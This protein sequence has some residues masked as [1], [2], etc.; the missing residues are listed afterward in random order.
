MVV[1]SQQ[2]LYILKE[3]VEHIEKNK[4]RD[5]SFSCRVVVERIEGGSDHSQVIS[6]VKLL[7][8]WAT[9]EW[10]EI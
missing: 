5:D 1:A 7:I 10:C 3:W 4:D 6:I 9:N 8:K 2:V